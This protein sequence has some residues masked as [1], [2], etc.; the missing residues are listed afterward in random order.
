M[1]NIKND[2]SYGE[3]CVI[4]KATLNDSRFVFNLR[5]KDYVQNISWNTKQI[6]IDEHESFWKK[7]YKFYWIIQSLT[8]KESIGFV[9]IKDGEVSIA[10]LKEFW[11]Q[12]Y[13]YFAIQEIKKNYPNLRAEVK[14]DNV[15]S[16]CFFVKC[17][18]VPSGFIMNDKLIVKGSE[19]E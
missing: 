9:R 11:N 2:W 17:G 14:M 6:T 12:S 15:H 13:G 1:D 18:F 4:C 16:F 3:V 8:D 19:K 10:I 5:N 7:N